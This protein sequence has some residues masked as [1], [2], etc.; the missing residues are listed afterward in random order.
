[1]NNFM[2]NEILNWLLAG[3]QSIIYQTNRDLLVT[4]EKN[5]NH[6]RKKIAYNG[7]GKQFLDKRNN[8]TGLWGNGIYSPKW[9][10]TTYTMLD[11]KNIGI[12]PETREYIESSSILVDR[13]WKIP[14]KSKEKYLDLCICGMLLNLCCYAG[15]DSSKINEIVDFILDKQFNDGGWNCRWEYDKDHSSLHT[16]INILEGLREYLDNG[17]SYKKKEINQAV[18]KA[19][20]FILMHNLFKS[21]KTKKII[22][23]DMIMLSYPSRWKYDILRCLDYFWSADEKYDRRMGDALEIIIKKQLK[24]NHW[25]VQKKHAGLV[26]YD[27]EETGKESRWNTLRAL[28]V[29]KKYKKDIFLEIFP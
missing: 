5:L 20:E 6:L 4:D 17:Y 1:M 22:H 25:P 16:T 18:I 9:I 19:H 15:I 29:L 24:N 11:L 13:L 14:K 26:H 7:W 23:K 21:D 28:R 27:M 3:D 2:S 8:E 12:H 10:S